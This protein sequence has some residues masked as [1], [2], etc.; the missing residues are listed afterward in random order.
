[1][2]DCKTLISYVAYYVSRGKAVISPLSDRLSFQG[3]VY[4]YRGYHR[5]FLV[6]WQRL[7]QQRDFCQLCLEGDTFTFKQLL[8]HRYEIN[9]CACCYLPIPTSMGGALDVP[10]CH[11]CDRGPSLKP[12]E[13]QVIASRQQCFGVPPLTQPQEPSVSLVQQLEHN[14]NLLHGIVIGSPPLQ[15]S[16][17]QQ[18]LLHNGFKLS[19]VE[20]PEVAIQLSQERP[21]D[22]VLIDTE[23][24]EPQGQLWS[25]QLHQVSSL[26]CTPVVGFSAE[27]GEGVPWSHQ[28]FSII[29][30]L[31][32]PLSGQH[33]AEQLRQVSQQAALADTDIYWFPRLPNS[34]PVAIAPSVSKA[35]TADLE[36]LLN[37]RTVALEIACQQQ[38]TLQQQVEELE[39]SHRRKD[40][41]LN[42]VSH[43]LRTPITNVKMA[44][45]MLTV[46]LTKAGVLRLHPST[47][48]TEQQKIAHYLQIL[49]LECDREISLI[50]ELLDLQRLE[51]DAQAWV[52]EPVQLQTWLPHL[53]EPFQTRTQQRQQKLQ[54]A[55]ESTLPSLTTDLS[56]LERILAELLNNACKY[57][58]AQ[59]QITL[60]VCNVADR[61][62]LTVSNSGIEIPLEQLPHIFERFYR[63]ASHDPWKE[64]GTG[65]GLTLV[66]KLVER[67]GG[68]ITVE[69]GG[70][71][72]QFRVELPLQGPQPQT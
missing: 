41:F 45:H 48:T 61:I 6:F 40:D 29:D 49:Q 15:I 9:E 64:R 50:N 44:I 7:E 31:L 28:R 69:S 66:Q 46:T 14:F 1:M 52:A 19:F 56:S 27:A 10:A 63:I 71:Q 53:V 67:L 55:I 18:L 32:M 16:A 39:N 34:T 17:V 37:E 13:R 30:Y 65:L 20:T 26:E 59:A 2:T 62:Q 42:T 33:L 21:I 47:P 68:K 51:S 57:T 54:I 12:S 24:S 22:L 25:Q 4:K 60:S 36:Q 58:P 72:T 8:E 38:H 70:Q 5:D 23:I 3:L 35:N 43:E 11:F